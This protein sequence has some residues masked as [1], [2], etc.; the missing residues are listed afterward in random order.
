MPRLKAHVESRSEIS[1]ADEPPSPNPQIV[2]VHVLTS[3]VSLKIGVFG[4]DTVPDLPDKVS[5][6]DAGPC[7]L[8]GRLRHRMRPQ[9]HGASPRCRR[10]AAKTPGHWRR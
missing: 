3:D 1:V 5:K 2:C 6:G 7:A 9:H 10:S 4:I 8:G